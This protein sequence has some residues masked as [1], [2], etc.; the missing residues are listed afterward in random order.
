MASFGEHRYIGRELPLF[1]LATT[2]KRYIKVALRGFLS[3]DVLEVGAGIGGT[4]IALHD[5]TAQWWVCLEPDPEN[6]KE[7]QSALIQSSHQSRTSV[8]AGTLCAVAQRP[9]F[10]CILY[11]DVL[12]HIEEDRIAIEAAARLVKNGGYIVILSPAHQWLFSEFDTTIGHLR[13]YSKRTLRSLTPSG[14][15]ECKMVY[16]DSVGFLLSLANL[17]VLKQAI[18]S[19]RQIHVWDRAC[20]PLSRVFDRLSFG[21]F[22]KS[23]LAVWRKP[24]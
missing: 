13:R 22:G 2:W 8:I 18:P 21:S 7:L 3:G 23:V 20:V 1:S 11:I 15:T 19:T 9:F 16:L 4:T 24:V 17:L 6:A 5:G 12:E 14:W 10:N